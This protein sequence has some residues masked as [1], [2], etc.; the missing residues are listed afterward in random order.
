MSF[1]THIRNLV[2]THESAGEPRIA[3]FGDSH[4]AALVGAKDFPQRKH[5]YDHIRV[6]RLLKEKNGRVVGDSRLEDFC[7]EIRNFGSN[8]LVFSA[9]G[10]NQYAVISTVRDPVE[11]DFLSSTEDTTVPMAGAALVPFRALSGY[12]KRGVRGTLGPILKEI[13]KATS[14]RVYHLAPPPPKEDNAFIATHFETRFAG[15]LEKLGPTHPELRLK[16]W[17]LQL[18][19]LADL[20]AE[21]NIGL[22]MPPKHGITARGF[23]APRCYAKDVTHGNRRYGEFVLKQILE[24][25]EGGPSPEP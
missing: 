4:T 12:I 6:Y 8:D 16:C 17:N 24:L 15:G 18:G 13:R 22:V 21:L 2:R 3:V 19:C 1:V 7:S 9:V 14:A 25:S 23:L 11:Y 5:L 20:C 10:G